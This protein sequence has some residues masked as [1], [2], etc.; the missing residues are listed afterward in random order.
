LKRQGVLK[1][2]DLQ[3]A[4]M[5]VLLVGFEHGISVFESSQA[6]ASN[7]FQILLYLS[8]RALYVSAPIEGPKSLKWIKNN[9]LLDVIRVIY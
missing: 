8:L 5:S 2:K 1:W 9:V 3:A 6:V 4:L 7:I